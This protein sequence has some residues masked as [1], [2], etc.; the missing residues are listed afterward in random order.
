M[1]EHQLRGDRRVRGGDHVERASTRDPM[2]SEPLATPRRLAIIA[3]CCSRSTSATPRP[4]SAPSRASEL[5]EHWRFQTRAGATGDELASGSPACSRS[6][7][8]ASARST[9]VCVS[10]VVPPLG[11]QYEQMAERYLERR[12]PAGRARG[13]DRDADPDRQ[14]ARGRRRPPRQRGRRL[15]PLRRA[16]ASSSTSAP[17]INFDAVS[18]DGEYLGGAIGPGPR[19]LAQALTERAARIARIELGE[20]RGGDRHA[21]P[22]PR[23]S[24]ASIFGFAGADRRRSSRRIED[25]LGRGRDFSPP[26]ARRARSSPSRETIDEV[27]DLLTL[28]GLRLI[29][30]RNAMTAA[31]RSTDPLRDRRRRDRQ[32]RPAGAAGRDRQL[33]RAPAGASATAPG[34][35]SRRWSPASRLHYRNERTLRELMR[36]HPDEHPVSIQLFGHDA[37]VMRSGAAI[38]AEAG[39]DLIDI[40]MGCPVPQGAQDRRRR[41]SCCATPSSRWRWPAARSRAAACR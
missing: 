14:P 6:A 25:E 24:P 5:V 2:R 10:S 22:A 4:T 19:D 27:D 40:N 29:Y 1:L 37:E 32:P 34:S 33:V 13:E 11:A 38:A 16:P 20:P 28:K 12:L 30:E 41:R 39:A 15:R 18:A 31:R 3:R 26:A 23:S 35:R 36:I 9:R 17:A 21:R 8:S 7:A